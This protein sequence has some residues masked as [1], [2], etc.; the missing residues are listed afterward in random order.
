VPLSKLITVSRAL[1]KRLREYRASPAAKLFAPGLV[2]EMQLVDELL[3][4]VEDL[5]DR[6]AL[7]EL[8]NGTYLIGD[9]ASG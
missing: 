8:A 4:H 1:R 6:V 9:R 5:D 3:E 2:G 7:L